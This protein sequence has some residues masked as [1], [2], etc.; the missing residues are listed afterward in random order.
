MKLRFLILS[1]SIAIGSFNSF[2][3]DQVGKYRVP[4]PA[5]EQ[6]ETWSISDVHNVDIILHNTRKKLIEDTGNNPLMRRDAHPKHHGCV[7]ASLKIDTK[8]LDPKFRLGLF[9][10]DAIYSSVIRFSNGSPDAKKADIDGDARGMAIKILGVPYDNYLADVGVEPASSS[11]DIL[12]INS[13]VF[14]IKD[15]ETYVK[16][17]ESVEKDGLGLLWFGI[18]H[19][20]T[21]KILW[22]IKNTQVFNPLDPTY[23][24]ATPYKLGDTSMRMKFVSCKK[25][26]AKPIAPEN[27]YLS[28]RLA[29]YLAVRGT[30]FDFYI[31]PNHDDHENDIENPMQNWDDKKSPY[32]KVGRLDIPKQSGIHTTT[33][34]EFCENISFNPWRAPEVNRPLGTMNRTRLEVYVKQGKF[35]QNYNQ[36]NDPS[37][38][39][40][41]NIP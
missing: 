13:P 12:V 39:E 24:S 33:S 37:P 1:L 9:A 14:F 29:E 32:I 36:A 4:Q 35:R 27:N 5:I 19:P 10:K 26:D 22:E 2:A 38:S 21:A 34:S 31:Q 28:D 25:A 30:C 18:T 20:Y 41:R 16:F 11:H 7:N 15:T 23:H 6:G 40:R 17:T 8:S 3:Q